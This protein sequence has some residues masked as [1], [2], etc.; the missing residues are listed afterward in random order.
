MAAGVWV[1]AVQL[2][3]VRSRRNWGHG[4]FSDLAP[5][6]EIDC[7]SRRRRGRRSTRCMRCSSTARNPAAPMRRTAGCF[8]IR[9]ISTSTAVEDFAPSGSPA[10]ELERLRAAE[11]VDY[12]RVAALKIARLA[13][14]L[15][16]LPA[17]I[18]SAERRQRFSKPTGPERGRALER[19]AAFES[20]RGASSGPVVGLAG[21][22]A[23]AR[24][25]GAAAHC[26]ETHRDECGFPRIPAM[27][28]RPPAR[29]AAGH[30]AAG[31]ACRSG[32]I[33]TSLSASIRPAPM[34]GWIRASMLR[35]LSIGAPPDQFNP[36][37]Q[38]WGLTAFNP[39]GLAANDFEPL[40]QMLRAGDASRRRDSARSRARPDAAV[41]HSRWLPARRR[42]PMCVFRSTTAG[43][44]RR[45]KPALACIVIG[46]DLG[47]VPEGFPR[48]ALGLG[49]LVL[50]GH[51]VRA[52]ADGEFSRPAEYPSGRSRPSTPTIWRPSPAG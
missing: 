28:R 35:G 11:L 39:H 14:G 24:R 7:G 47:T 16:T 30:R 36:A 46:E 51:D 13:R 22:V 1:L 18:G 41:R 19:F 5:I 10:S 6:L 12:R 8:S 20:L 38:D 27:D 4:D 49:R 9:S 33:S 23:A 44:H 3:A 31:A 50:S 43:G 29:G 37:G 25:R 15:S 17:R 42:A 48:H 21:A 45:G 32:S 40:R 2:Y 52:Q 34:P 26:G